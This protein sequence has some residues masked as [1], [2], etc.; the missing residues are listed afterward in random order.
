MCHA[1]F[2]CSPDKIVSQIINLAWYV[3]YRLIRKLNF[4]Y[5]FQSCACTMIHIGTPAYY[6][7]VQFTSLM[8]LYYTCRRINN[9]A[10][11]TKLKSNL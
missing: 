11:K 1:T 7:N 4:S 6:N 5:F 8:F 9:L 2:C 10:L 3:S